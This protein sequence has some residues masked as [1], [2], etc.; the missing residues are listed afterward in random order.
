M[1]PITVQSVSAYPP[2]TCSESF[3]ISCHDREIPAWVESEIEQLY[4]NVY[5]SIPKLAIYGR[6]DDISTYIVRR[7]STPLTIYL[8]RN[9]G[10][11]VRV[12]NELIKVDEDNINR[13]AKTIFA[14]YPS[15]A[16]IT[17]HA[18]RPDIHHLSYPYQLFNHAEDIVI[19]LPASIDEYLRRLSKSTRRTIRSYANKLTTRNPSFRFLWCEKEQ[20]KEDEIRE[21]IRMNRER[22]RIKHRSSDITEAE[23]LRIVKMVRSCGLVGVATIDDRI[24]G[25]T[26]AYRSGTNFYIVVSAHDPVYDDLR[27]GTLCSYFAV[28]ECIVRGGEECHFLWGR[29]EYKFSLLGVSRNLDNLTVYRSATVCLFN[30]D[31]VVMT[32][33]EGYV[34][35][36]KL[37]MHDG[38]HQHRRLPRAVFAVVKGVR[39][40][41]RLA[42][43]L[44]IR[45][46]V[47]P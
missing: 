39:N 5:A 29:Y 24:C 20:A 25:G 14:T 33:V 31:R 8:F 15:V 23:T 27:L 21:I 36:A 17:F 28:C 12:L 40:M 19:L 42:A 35:Q 30:A 44:F 9:D 1:D 13:F 2:D 4:E 37:W 45:R 22:M 11:T 32:A 34:R 6:L 47:D 10:R 16:A 38:L 41:S 43:G 18:I 7:G 46:S 26:I 3:V